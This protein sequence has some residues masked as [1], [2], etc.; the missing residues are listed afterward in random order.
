MLNDAKTTT[1]N[2]ERIIGEVNGTMAIEG[3]PLT[4]DDKICIRRV[5]NG[6]VPLEEMIRSAI[7]EFVADEPQ[8]E[9]RI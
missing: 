6:E 4:D 2:T 9:L 3:M 5:L 8:Y 1:A 7:G